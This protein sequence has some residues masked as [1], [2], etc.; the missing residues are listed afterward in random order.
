M[1][2]VAPAPQ[3]E[4]AADLKYIFL[5]MREAATTFNPKN[6]EWYAD[7]L[8]GAIIEYTTSAINNAIS[9]MFGNINSRITALETRVTA[10]ENTPP[11]NPEDNP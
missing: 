5:Q 8:A 4:L 2:T 7:W 11:P 1:A 9:S 6:D 3:S 10:L